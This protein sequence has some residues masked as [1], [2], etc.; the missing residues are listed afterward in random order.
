MTRAG[1]GGHLA[2]LL[3]DE[4][5]RAPE[6]PST[7]PLPSDSRLRKVCLRLIEEPAIDFD[8]DEWAQQSA[9]SRRS[10]TRIFR[11]ETG[12]SFGEWRARARL[13]RALALEAEAKPMRDVAAAVGYRSLR[14]LRARM[15][16][17]PM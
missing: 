5:K 17:A 6:T 3:L 10:F 15:I 12:V 13:V 11:R 7:L 4:I 1:R 16:A 14:A 2:A 8:I 9:V